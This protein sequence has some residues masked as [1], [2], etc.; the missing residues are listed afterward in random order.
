MD[1]N[2]FLK[3][4]KSVRDF[5]HKDLNTDKISAIK[6]ALV[7][8][9]DAKGADAVEFQL[10]ENA[11]AIHSQLNGKA[12]YSGVMIKAPAYI[13]MS[14]NN[15]GPA[16]VIKGA[17]A[18]EALISKLNNLGLGTCWVTL[19]DQ[20]KP[21]AR[22]IFGE[23]G[24]MIDY[25]LAI[26]EPEAKKPFN[27]LPTSRRKSVEELVF[28]DEGFN[29]SAVEKLKKLNMLD[30]F[31]N[32]KNAPS[33]FNK[34]P[35]YFVLKDSEIDLFLKNDEDLLYS[36]TDGG[37]V[38]Y[39]FAALAKLMGLDGEWKLVDTFDYVVGD[40]VKVGSYKI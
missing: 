2:N 10:W 7:E 6:D 19:Y 27:P 23:K 22:E 24:D 32:L 8:V 25:V 31:S 11:D 3:K 28:L 21:A 16:Y 15:V 20:A 30:L 5:I 39:Y 17:Y 26:G 38:M 36:L 29:K 13:T 35:W 18:M 14:Y 33:H 34:Q 4:R 9:K 12:G 37:I 40:K 1:M